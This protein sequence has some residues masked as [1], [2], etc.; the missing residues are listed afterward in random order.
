MSSGF[1]E[2]KGCNGRCVSICQRER[3]K[4]KKTGCVALKMASTDGKANVCVFC[5]HSPQ[6]E[7]LPELSVER[8]AS[9][10]GAEAE[11]ESR[12]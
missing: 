7:T 5:A 11:A 9:S 2:P 3:G 4:R 8:P 12:Q 6:R 1:R 10:S